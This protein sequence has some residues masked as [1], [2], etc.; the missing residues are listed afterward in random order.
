VSGYNEY[1][2][3]FDGDDLERQNGGG[4]RKQLEEALAANKKLSERLT[5]L[6]RKDSVTGL[7]K[8]K[9]I[10]PAAAGLVPTDA[11]PM[12]WI[13][14]N[15]HLLAKA[16]ETPMDLKEAPTPEVEETPDPDLEAEQRQLEDLQGA[17]ETGIPS[18]ATA[19]Q[20]TKLKSFETEAELMAYIQS[21][22][23]V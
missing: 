9:G 4:L 20:I 11:D 23:T 10:A 16:V 7:L 22:G 18:T 21:G 17:S 2:E 13:E 15:G 19:D 14:E 8:E 1:S 3:M 5:N 6:E 12:K